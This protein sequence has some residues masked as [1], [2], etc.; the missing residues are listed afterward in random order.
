MND[1]DLGSDSLFSC[2][3]YKEKVVKFYLEFF[4]ESKDLDVYLQIIDLLD[5]DNGF[6]KNNMLRM[7]NQIQRF[8]E[9]ARESEFDCLK[10]L[11]FYICF[12]SLAKL[13][14]LSKNQFLKCF[15]N[16]ITNNG[17]NYLIKNFVI[18]YK[19]KNENKSKDA[20][21]IFF[22]LLKDLRNSIVHEGDCWYNVIFNNKMVAITQCVGKYTYS[23][24]LKYK[25]FEKIIV[26]S[27]LQFVFSNHKLFNQ[28]E[29]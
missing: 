14:G 15:P 27:C 21:C 6:S 13:N 23:T 8:V 1:T 19:N 26:K 20:I 7:F 28:N 3:K 25:N 11:Y 5:N 18:E 10:I 24:K 29:I 12:E 9:L 17:K 16:Y 22:Q 2:K 4:K